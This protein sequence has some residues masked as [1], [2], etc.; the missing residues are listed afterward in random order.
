VTTQADHYET[1]EAIEAWLDTKGTTLW[2]HAF[3]LSQP[4]S[5]V[6]AAVWFLAQMEELFQFVQ[7]P[8]QLSI[9][10]AL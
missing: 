10:D 4:E 5:K 2:G 6:Q 3:D 9:Y 1:L 8:I 7:Q